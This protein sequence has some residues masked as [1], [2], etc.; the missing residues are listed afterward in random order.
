MLVPRA[1][2]QKHKMKTVKNTLT[3]I[4]V[5]RPTNHLIGDMPKVGIRPVIDGR[6][7]G[8]REPCIMRWPGKIPAA[9]T[10]N[11]IVGNID[12]LPTFAKLVGVELPRD[13]AIDGRDITPLL[14]DPQAGPVRDT[15]LYFAVNSSLAAIRQGD[16]KLFLNTSND[17]T[18]A[19]SDQKGRKKASRAGK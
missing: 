4:K 13:R 12:M 10:C 5:N 8:V 16:W 3:E 14:F 11:Q 18:Q 17:S 2:R 9:T 1:G 19:T 6:R 15:H 7:N